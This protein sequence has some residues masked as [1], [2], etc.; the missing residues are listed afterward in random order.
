MKKAII[1]L[2]IF[3]VILAFPVMAERIST[4][5]DNA[6]EGLGLYGFCKD[7]C[8]LFQ[9]GHRIY[10]RSQGARDTRQTECDLCLDGRLFVPSGTTREAYC[11][12][13]CAPLDDSYID[14]T[15][16]A[17]DDGTITFTNTETS[18]S[19]TIDPPSSYG[20]VDAWNQDIKEPALDRTIGGGGGPPVPEFNSIYSILIVIGASLILLVYLRKK[21]NK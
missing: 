3:L 14:V 17:N 21:Y 7:E 11:E 4:N 5:D 2:L 13:Y 10:D 9:K 1:I 8:Y 12:R 19:E 18:Y 20:E 6:K 16:T 15:E